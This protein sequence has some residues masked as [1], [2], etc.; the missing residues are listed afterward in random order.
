MFTTLAFAKKKGV[1]PAG[2][3]AVATITQMENASVKADMDGDSS[4]VEKNYADSF[5]GGSSWENW[6]TSR[7]L[8]T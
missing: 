7:Y 3:D 5:S 8:P 1:P 4:Y 6:E 2:T